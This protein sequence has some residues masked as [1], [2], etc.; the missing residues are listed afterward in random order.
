MPATRREWMGTL[1]A[2]G[3]QTAAARR[4][5]VLLIMSDDQG[6]G[7]FSCHGNPH[8]KTPNL[9]RLAGEG[10]EF[11]RFYVS[12]VCAPTRASLLTGRYH[13]RSGVHGVT[14]GRETMRTSEVTLAEAMKPAGYR[15]A[16]IGKWHLGEHYPYLPHAQGFDE[17]I[18]FRTGHWTEYWDTMLERNGKPYPTR[19]YIADVFTSEAIRFLEANARRPFFLYLAYNTPHAPYL[20]PEHHWERYRKMDL[21]PQVAAV[22]SMVANLD[23]N[24]GRLMAALARLNLAE[25]TIVLFLTDNG[26]N[27]QR[28]NAGLRAAKGS[29]YDGGVRT[30]L[31]VRWPKHVEAGRKIPTL[32]AHIDVLPTV[33]DLCG[34]SRTSGPPLD[35]MSLR[36]LLEGG[37]TDW[38]D[39]KIFTWRGLRDQGGMYPGAVRTG[40]FHLINGKEL[41]EIAA[42]PGEKHDVAAGHP[43]KVRELRAAYE[44]W[45][46]KAGDECGFARPVIPAGYDEENPVELPAPQAYLEGELRYSRGSG[47]AHEWVTNWRRLEDSVYWELE[48]VKAGRYQIR[49]RYLCPPGDTGSKLKVSVA[50]KTLEA[51][52]ETPT[53][54]EPAPHRDLIPRPEVPQMRWAMLLMGSL[55]LPKGRTQ[56]RVQAVEKPGTAVL[57]LEAATLTRI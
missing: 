12:P 42:D 44:A 6:Y 17:F 13:L 30:P 15:T 46:R 8:L 2:A 34:V 39:R 36:A 33:L 26:P 25:D 29:V 3:L 18:G 54:M 37:A 22:Y 27:G 35:G 53:S 4:P 45:F 20:A 57:E 5:N 31:F 43:E 49:L 9:D 14:T 21:P 19:G 7:D 41:Y 51:K 55:D 48:I 28:Y 32:A 16:L 52:L 10:A 1:A 56:L 11:T 40:R 50:G 23:E 24:I 47:F 38:P